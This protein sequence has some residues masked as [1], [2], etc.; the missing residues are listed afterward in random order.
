MT[1]ISSA[2]YDSAINAIRSRVDRPVRVG[3]ILGSGLGR[4]ANYVENPAHVLYNDIPGFPVPTVPGHT[5][6][7]VFG[8]L[9]GVPLVMQQG[10]MHFYEGYSEQQVTFPTRIMKRLGAEILIVTNAA[11]GINKDFAVGD[12]MLINDHLNFVGLAGHNPL[13]GPNDEAFGA[14]FI[15]TTQAYDRALA[16]TARAVAARENIPMREG[17]YA[18]VSGPF[19]E[20]PAEIRMLRTLGADTVGMSTVHEV[21]IAVHAGMRVLA[22]SGVTNLCVDSLD[23]HDQPNHEEVLEAG[24]QINPRL[25]ALL[26]GVL[27]AL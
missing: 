8:T 18:G 3:V 10:R 16:Q 2:A 24:E 1:I 20:S 15:S 27:R 12:V 19:Y 14:R 13:M 22:F 17:V 6:R 21:L 7:L 9:E 11:G 23:S 25:T 26:R 5:G 4:L